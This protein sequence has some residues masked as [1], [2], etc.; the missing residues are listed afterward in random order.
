MK[1]CGGA[2][3]RKELGIERRFRDSR[4]ARV[5]APTTDALLDFIGRAIGGLPLLDAPDGRRPSSWAPSPTTPRSSPS[6]TA[7]GGGSDVRSFDFDYVLY[8]NYERQVEDLVGRAHPRRRGTRRWPGFGPSAWR[9]RRGQVRAA[10]HAGH[11]QRPRLGRSWCRR[12]GRRLASAADLDGRRVGDGRRRL[13]T[14]HP[15]PARPSP[16]GTG[17]SRADD[18]EV[19]H[20]DVGVGLHGDHIGGEREAA[21]ALIGG[22]GRRRLHDRLA[23]ISLFGREA[24]CRPAA[25]T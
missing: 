17:S 1:V 10:G 15:A 5:M 24:P 3:F 7:S 11:R 12:R 19:R 22:D 2:A 16:R 6:G 4:A 14:G 21:A 23:T 18:F 20:F 8:S 25:T 13:A 9:R